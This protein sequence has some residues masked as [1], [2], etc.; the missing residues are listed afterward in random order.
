MP[1]H[2]TPAAKTTSTT[3]RRPGRPQKQLPAHSETSSS[4]TE[5]DPS[6]PQPSTSAAQPTSRGRARQR[7]TSHPSRSSSRIARNIIPPPKPPL[8]SSSSEPD[9][10]SSTDES[11]VVEPQPQPEIPQPNMANQAANKISI[12]LPDVM[13]DNLES[14]LMLCDI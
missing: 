9:T 8:A 10:S 11:V 12:K 2:S 7:G 3:S 1:S 5:L 14:W 13:V 4:S 6:Q